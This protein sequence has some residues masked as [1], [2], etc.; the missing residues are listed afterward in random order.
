MCV[1]DRC[2]GVGADRGCNRIVD[3]RHFGISEKTADFGAGGL[4]IKSGDDAP[5]LSGLLDVA[6]DALVSFERQ[7]PL[8]W[9]PQGA[10]DGL[11]LLKVKLTQFGLPE[12]QVA[13]AEG[14]IN[15]FRSK[16]RQ[17]PGALG[18]RGEELYDRLDVQR[19]ESGVES[20]AL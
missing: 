8:E 18:I 12:S 20:G 16:F 10:A 11:E 2:Q 9:Q 13:E 7:I 5:A 4:E 6:G 3:G 17:Q 14:H 1:I 19:L 15:V